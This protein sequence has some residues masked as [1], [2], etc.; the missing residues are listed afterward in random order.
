MQDAPT[1]PIGAPI[2]VLPAMAGRPPAIAVPVDPAPPVF[3]PTRP[4][5]GLVRVQA[6]TPIEV[7]PEPA[8]APK[9]AVKSEPKRLA[10]ATVEKKAEVKPPESQGRAEGRRGRAGE[11]QG[12]QGEGRAQGGEGRQGGAEEG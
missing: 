6:V 8:L 3:A 5:S 7:E 11:D 4:P 9:P 10:G 2:E 12:P 1:A